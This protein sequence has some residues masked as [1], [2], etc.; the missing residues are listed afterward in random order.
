MR[1][2]GVWLRGS[3]VEIRSTYVVSSIINQIKIM[4]IKSRVNKD[5]NKDIKVEVELLRLSL[6]LF[7]MKGNF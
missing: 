3:E 7:I 5:K 2:S 1:V 4:K 6:V